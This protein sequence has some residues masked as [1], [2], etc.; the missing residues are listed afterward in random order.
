MAYHL[1]RYGYPHALLLRNAFEPSEVDVTQLLALSASISGDPTGGGKSVSAGRLSDLGNTISSMPS[2][3]K[4][5][6]SQVP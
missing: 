5:R 1:C 2:M 6:C 3:E 4:E